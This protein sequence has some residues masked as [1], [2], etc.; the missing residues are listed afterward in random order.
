MS[1]TGAL[2]EA[3]PNQPQEDFYNAPII[4][5]A[6]LNVGGKY[7]ANVL[8]EG[9]LPLALHHVIPWNLLRDFWNTLQE[10]Q[11]WKAI[12]IYGSMI[13]VAQP[14]MSRLVD[15]M[16]R[17]RFAN[18]IDL[19]AKICWARWNLVRGPQHRSDDPGEDLDDMRSRYGND[20]NNKRIG[21]LLA[22]GVAMRQ[23]LHGIPT[24]A[25]IVEAIVEMKRKLNRSDV[26]EFD[27]EIWRVSSDSPSFVAANRDAFAVQPLW[28]IRGRSGG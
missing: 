22:N 1:I 21:F 16:R 25:T 14:T 3:R 11:Y 6:G 17:A 5:L 4:A 12:A 7:P 9:F 24:E 27:K 19:D 26:M 2:H 15:A 20:A 13:G 23:W 28:H 18:A 8:Q 10:K